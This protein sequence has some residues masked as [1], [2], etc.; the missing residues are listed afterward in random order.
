ML[1]FSF[2]FEPSRLNENRTTRLRLLTLTYSSVTHQASR[3]THD[4]PVCVTHAN[5]GTT[6]WTAVK[7]SKSSAGAPNKPLIGSG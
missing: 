2:G 6:R 1:K 7:E 5:V 4:A 3:D